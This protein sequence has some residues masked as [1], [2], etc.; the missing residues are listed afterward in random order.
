MSVQSESIL[1]PCVHQPS[2]TE[3]KEL[4]PKKLVSSGRDSARN[5]TDTRTSIGDIE[6][7]SISR[8]SFDSYRRSFVCIFWGFQPGNYLPD[9][10]D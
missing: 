5:S 1:T 7:F 10:Q 4:W 2:P 6:H 9:M 3:E 8:E